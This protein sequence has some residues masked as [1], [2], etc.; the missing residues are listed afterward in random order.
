MTTATKATKE[1]KVT[2]PR[3]P[4][5][6]VK[7]DFPVE[8]QPIKTTSGIDIP[9]KRAVVRTDTKKA[10]GVVG[11]DYHI[12]HNK[13]VL[14]QIEDSLPVALATRSINICKGGVYM[15]ARYMSPKIQSVQV[16]K[17]D[18]VQFGVE[19]FN[20]YNGKTALG[21]RMLAFRLVCTNGMTTPR[22][23]STIQVR[24]TANVSFIDARKEF[25]KKVELFYKY[26]D[27][28]KKWP[29]MKPTDAQIKK[30]LDERIS[31][32]TA[33]EIILN[34]Y[35]IDKDDSL[36]GFYNAVTWYGTHVLKPTLAKHLDD[37]TKSM[38]GVHG[39]AARLQF[40]YARQ[41]VEPFYEYQW[42]KN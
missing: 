14:K 29:T 1:T 9:N 18:I 40:K 23:I 37:K 36:W 27:T 13:E 12:L 41:V 24:H 38:S 21:M 25:E 17:G 4:E 5:L 8:M 31:Q 34:K 26:A 33:K 28:W 20:S 16:A 42:G 3:F 39:D 10:L 30:F 2:K 7:Y 22:S 32:K 19:I 15:F 35:S 6:N 11:T